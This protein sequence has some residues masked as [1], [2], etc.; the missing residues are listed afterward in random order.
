MLGSHLQNNRF[1]KKANNF[2]IICAKYALESR[3]GSV[4]PSGVVDSRVR[5][6]STARVLEGVPYLI[7]ASVTV[8]ARIST[9]ANPSLECHWCT[10]A[11]FKQRHFKHQI[12]TI[13]FCLDFKVGINHC[14]KWLANELAS[15]A[16]LARA[17]VILRIRHNAVDRGRIIDASS[18][19]FSAIMILSISSTSSNCK[20]WNSKRPYLPADLNWSDFSPPKGHRVLKTLKAFKNPHIRSRMNK[21]SK[22]A[23]SLIC[24]LKKSI[25]KPFLRY[26]KIFKER[27]I[28]KI[29]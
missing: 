10:A 4:K 6:Q 2:P 28:F 15:D 21:F 11:H 17:T 18:Y 14:L 26:L 1:S 13:V 3:A 16:W 7:W 9:L 19:C 23:S 25:K 8:L 24:A 29:A 20:I 22:R 5:L 12:L 27:K